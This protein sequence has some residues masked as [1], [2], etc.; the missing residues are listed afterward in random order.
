MLNIVKGWEGIM[1]KRIDSISPEKA[2]GEIKD[3]YGKIEKKFGRVP[4]IFQAMA[5]SPAVLKAFLQ[6]N[7]AAGQSSFKPEVVNEIALVVAETNA[8]H[9]CLSAHTAG[10]HA[11]GIKDDVIQAARLGKSK[12]P[13][14]NAILHLA[15]IIVE[16]RG[17]LTDQ[18]IQEAK[19]AGINDKEITEIIFI[20]TINIFTNY[21]NN[22][23]NT[24]VDF[25]EVAVAR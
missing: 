21:F 5:N 6:L 2:S 12:D 7:E 19:K 4:N 14:T 24:E 20:V 1:S 3:L 9:Y 18:D 13:R 10:A 23:V 15:K 17:H 16:K 11:A 22:S 8:C 25:P